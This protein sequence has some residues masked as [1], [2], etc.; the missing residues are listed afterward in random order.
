[1]ASPSSTTAVG[2]T[3]R[4]SLSSELAYVGVICVTI[5]LYVVLAL[6]SLAPDGT[7]GKL[8]PLHIKVQANRYL[9]YLLDITGINKASNTQLQVAF[10][11][12]LIFML[13]A[14]AWAVFIFRRREDKGLF[15]ILSFTLL[16]CFLLTVIPPLVSKDVYSNIFY[17]KIAARYGSNPYIIT[18]QRFASDQLMAYVS[19]NWK[20]TAIVYGPLHTYLSIFMNLVAGHGI[21]ANIYVF[22]GAMAIFHLINTLLVWGI[23]AYLAPGR[24]RFGTMIYAWNPLALIIGVGGGHNDLMMMTFVLIALFFLVRGK[25]WPGYVFLCLS[26]MVKYI[27]IILVV[28]LIIYLIFRKTRTRD[29]LRDL[30]IYSAIFA[31][32]FFILFLPFWEGFNTFSSTLRNLQIN[33]YISIGGLLSAAFSYILE[34]VFMLPTT[35]AETVGMVMSRLILLP[36]FFAALWIIPRRTYKWVNLPNCFFLVTLAYLLTAGYYMPWY[37]LWI[38]PLIPLRAWDRLSKY[39]LAFGTATISLGSDLHAY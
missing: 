32:I 38:L 24:Q 3:W 17:A 22:K 26:V 36:I 20:N 12:L 33:N 28:A 29:R 6:L 1:V 14:Y 27:T 25:K 39:T 35:A 21:T 13:I 5:F 16:L 8:S 11:I 31:A 2:K 19:L 18:P 37:F 10:F 23:L 15:S 7:V 4:E 34:F 9:G 30:F